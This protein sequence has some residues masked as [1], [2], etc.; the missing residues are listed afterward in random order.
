MMTPDLLMLL[1]DERQRELRALAAPSAPLPL[2][3]RGR[4]RAAT[5]LIKAGRLLASGDVLLK[6]GDHIAL[7]IVEATALGEGL[8]AGEGLALG[9]GELPGPCLFILALAERYCVDNNSD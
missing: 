4:E 6:L 7:S 9:V 1:A 3:R 5:W 8:N 2:P